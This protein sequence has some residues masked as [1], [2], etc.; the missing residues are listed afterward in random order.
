[1]TGAA[2]NIG[3]AKPARPKGVALSL[4]AFYRKYDLPWTPSGDESQR[5]RKI[6]LAIAGGVLFLSAAVPLLPTPEIEI[7]EGVDVPPRLAKLVIEKKQPP[8]PPPP[9]EPEPEEVVAEATPEPEKAPEPEPEPPPEPKPE[10]KVAF[11]PEPEP[12]VALSID[13]VSRRSASSSARATR[14]DLAA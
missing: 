2:R 6:F 14:P 4:P 11:V 9:P 1:M 7:N 8:P 3:P 12:E 13:D 5:L 10:P